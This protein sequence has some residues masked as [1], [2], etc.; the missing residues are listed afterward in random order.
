MQSNDQLNKKPTNPEE[1]LSSRGIFLFS[2]YELTDLLQIL[3]IQ[4]TGFVR[5]ISIRKS[6]VSD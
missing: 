1:K 6:V 3:L 4:S 2:N 5:L